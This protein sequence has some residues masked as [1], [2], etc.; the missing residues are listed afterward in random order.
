MRWS[1]KDL[2]QLIENLC[3]TLAVEVKAWIDPATPHG[4]GIIARAAIAMRNNDGGYLVLGF[5]N[6]TLLPLE[7]ARP[8]NHRQVY[9]QDVIQ[10]IVRRYASEGFEVEVAFVKRAGCEYPVIVVPAG[11]KTPVAA[12]SDLYENA[13]GK[14][15][16]AEHMVYV[17]SLDANNTASTTCAKWQDW[18]GLVERCMDNREAD[19]GRFMRRYLGPSGLAA[20]SSVVSPAEQEKRG[21]HDAETACRKLMDR[22]KQRF[23]EEN[24]SR[25]FS[26]PDV[27]FWEVAL[28]IEGPTAESHAASQSFLNLISSCNPGLT[29][30]PIWLDSRTFCDQKAKPYVFDNAWEAHIVS[31]GGEW[32]DH[33]DFWRMEPPRGF[34]LLRVIDDDIA[35]SPNAPGPKKQL[36][37]GIL[38]WRVAEAIAVGKRFAE[39][40]KFDSDTTRL[41]FLFHWNGLRNRTLSSWANPRRMLFSRETRQD[42]LEAFVAVPEAVADSALYEYVD[43]IVK[44]VFLIFDGC[45]L[46][47]KVVQDIVAE[48]LSRGRG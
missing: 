21:G 28:T 41:H 9:H 4:V 2:G 37:F 20:L 17:R 7:E 23:K 40:L 18:S 6:D 32:S 5:D 11:V 39:A 16:V 15:L 13:C 22:G 36:D 47:S 26:P 48:L 46:S 19:I 43:A 33:L 10:G 29:G 25:S 27:G 35:R 45:E 30:W 24:D 3:E 31:L 14:K 1:D 34:Y 42:D 8:A 12:R 38:I 44:K